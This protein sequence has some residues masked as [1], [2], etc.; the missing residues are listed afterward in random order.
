MPFI[1]HTEEEVREMLAAIGAGSI[2]ELFDEIPGALRGAQLSG[3]PEGMSEQEIARLMGQRAAQDGQPLCFIGAGAYEHH[4]PAAVWEITTRGEFYSAY[5]PYQAE[6]SQGTLQVIYEFQTMMARLMAMEV[7]NASLYDG[8]SALAEAVLMAVRSNRGSKSGR[9]LLP[10]AVHPAYRRTTRTIVESQGIDLVEVPYDPQGGHTPLE[11]LERYEGQDITALVV[12]QPNFF[13]IL[14]EVDALTDW[15]HRNGALVIA[16]VN[17]IAMAVLT[18][19]GQWGESGADIV[20]GE[21]Q[22]LGV[23]LSSGGPYFGFMCCKKSY[24]R[25]MPGRI[26]G[27]TVDRDGR[28]GY[29]LTLQAREQHIRRSKATSNIC[30]NQGLLVTAAT[31]HMS[32]LGGEG[33]ARVGEACHANTRKLVARLTDNDFVRPRFDRPFFHECAL[34]FAIPLRGVIRPFAAHNLLPGY[35]LSSDYPELGDALLVCA[36]ETKTDQDLDLYA[37]HLR[38]MLEKQTKAGCPVQPKMA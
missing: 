1:P 33:L 32:L 11:A 3:V 36:T 30:T 26:V 28:A 5:T 9:V 31:V 15:A 10:T 37:D 6:A 22:P 24:V 8:A 7:S 27:R 12:P 21:G 34:Q 4:I 16:V 20:C 38:R 29:T 35:E 13:G 14:E 25:Q 18:P 19:P 17:P 23:P 2:E